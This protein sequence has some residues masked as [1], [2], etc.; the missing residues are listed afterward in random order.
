MAENRQDFEDTDVQTWFEEQEEEEPVAIE[1]PEESLQQ[2]YARSQLRVVR[3]T[4]DYTLDYLRH[5]LAPAKP[6]IDISPSYQRRLRWSRKKRSLLIESFLLN[7]PIP[8]IFLYERDYNEYEVIDG[9]QRLQ[10]VNEFLA[11]NYSLTG[12][13]YWPE[14]NGER[15]NNLPVVI[16]K[17]LLRRSLPA[18][19]LLAE[20]MSPDTDEVDVRTVL[21]D[22][23]N[24]GGEKLNPQEL[25]NALYAGPFNEMLIR[26]ARAPVFT[27]TWNIPAYTKGEETE[28][29]EELE[30]NTLFRTMADCELVLRFFAIRDAI[31]ANRKGSLRRILDRFTKE[32]ARD[33]EE[34]AK[35]FEQEFLN[36]LGVLYRTFDEE[37][38]KLPKSYRPSRPLYDALTVA[39]SL[40]RDYDPLPNK[41][42]IQASL[43][44][45]LGKKEQYDILVGRGNTISAV[46]DRVDL[47][48]RILRGEN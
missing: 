27:Q 21:F 24:T 14:L 3:E 22:R 32:H 1:V 15:F 35:Q 18:V 45:A 12:L 2:K 37:P 20:T 11:N 23:L 31:L 13:S 9:R 19:V 16:Q 10:A 43:Q 48:R 33:K 46:R 30:K 38:F 40:E 42:N 44:R 6:L 4:K 8:P 28:M 41:Q 29:P 26:A 5:A 34:Q 25:R 47:A 17:G 39:L 36:V 7:I